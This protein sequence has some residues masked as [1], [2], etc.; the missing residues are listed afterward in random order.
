MADSA[1]GTIAENSPVQYFSVEPLNHGLDGQ[2]QEC[3]CSKSHRRKSF[4]DWAIV[5]QIALFARP[6]GLLLRQAACHPLEYVP[7]YHVGASRIRLDR[8]LGVFSKLYDVRGC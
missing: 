7:L 8:A 5:G 6:L 2:V 4:R 3:L 1:F